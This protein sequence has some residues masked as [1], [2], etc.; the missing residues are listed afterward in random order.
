MLNG[1]DFM[2]RSEIEPPPAYSPTSHPVRAEKLLNFLIH[3]PTIV[4]L[5]PGKRLGAVLATRDNVLREGRR[6]LFDEIAY[7]RVAS[8]PLDAIELNLHALFEKHLSNC[9]DPRI[10]DKDLDIMTQH[11]L[12][13]RTEH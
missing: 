7:S 3:H 10:A 11:S 6:H 5:P 9:I 13:D 8:I 4:V 12:H 2:H 1:S